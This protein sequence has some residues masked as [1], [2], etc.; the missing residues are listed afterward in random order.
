MTVFE[1]QLQHSEKNI[2]DLSDEDYTTLLKIFNKQPKEDGKRLDDYEF[3]YEKLIIDDDELQ[4][5]LD[6]GLQVT[7]HRIRGIRYDNK[8]HSQY[9]VDSNNYRKLDNVIYQVSV[10]N[11][12]LFGIDEL[13][14]MEDACTWA[15]NDMLK[16][17]WRII[18]V[19]PPNDERRPTYII[20]R[21]K[22][23]VKD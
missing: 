7:L 22:S 12:G 3:R 13:D 9:N 8:F 4:V 17:G 10:S 5:I 19:C 16:A 18:A 20:G 21:N 14:L 2:K 15:V 23:M 1:V 6:M 11:V